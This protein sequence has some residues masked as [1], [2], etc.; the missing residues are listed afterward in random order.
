MRPIAPE[1]TDPA[2][3]TRR[4]VLYF[5][6]LI[7]TYVVAVAAFW[8]AEEKTGVFIFVMFAPTVGALLARFLGPGVIRWGRPSWWILAG[9]LPVPAALGAYYVGSWLGLD[10]LDPQTLMR[11]LVAAPVAF[12]SA[13][14]SAVGEEIG[15]RGFLWPLM[16]SRRSFLVS[17]LIVGAI[18]WLYHLPLILFGWYGTRSGVFAF[19]VAIAGFT[20]FVG[21]LTDRS[22]SIW[23]SVVAHGGWNALVATGF[24]VTT[25][26]GDKLPAFAGSTTWAGEFGWLA[27]VAM[28][29]LGGVTAAW[30]LSRPQA[31]ATA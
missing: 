5:G 21:V 10:T 30:H 8:S 28:L 17:S 2:R 22:K 15:W 20:L 18:W 11:A 26:A 4:L 13:C 6:G 3:D 7:V 29:V 24:A 12:F 9:L 27:A 14:L 19:T 16:R 23:P 31:D 25:L 1:R